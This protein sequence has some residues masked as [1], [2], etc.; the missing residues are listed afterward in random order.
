MKLFLSL[1]LCC[2]LAVG[3]VIACGDDEVN[4]CHELCQKGVGCGI[5][6]GIMESG[7][8]VCTLDCNNGNEPDDNAKYCALACPLTLPCIDYENCLIQC[9][10]DGELPDPV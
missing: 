10:F 5:M 6:G 8:L 3:V 1:I 4:T 9:D 7:W 2:G